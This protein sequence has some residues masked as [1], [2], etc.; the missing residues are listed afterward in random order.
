[1]IAK[2]IGALV[3][4]V[5]VG[6]FMVSLGMKAQDAPKSEAVSKLQKELQEQRAQMDGLDIVGAPPQPAPARQ[7]GA[8]DAAE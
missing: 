6:Y 2:V 1:M 5:V 7:D 3:V 4:L 8:E